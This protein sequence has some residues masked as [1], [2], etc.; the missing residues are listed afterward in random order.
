MV[1]PL[2]IMAG[3]AI[4]TAVISAYQQW[5]QSE[6]GRNASAAESK[7]M[8]ELLAK[9]QTPNFDPSKLTPEDYAVVRKHIPQVAEYVAEANPSLVKADSAGA[10]AGR[11]AQQHR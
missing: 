8:E 9:V 5:K 2:V 11:D 10:I 1:A 3:V 7:K 4:G 6:A